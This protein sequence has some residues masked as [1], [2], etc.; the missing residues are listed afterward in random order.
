MSLYYSNHNQQMISVEYKLTRLNAIPHGRHDRFYFF[1]NGFF[2][3][4][5]S[6]KHHSQIVGNHGQRPEITAEGGRNNLYLKKYFYRQYCMFVIFVY[7]FI[8]F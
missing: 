5:T 6:Q 3:V 1:H 7:P 2:S 8:Q 4:I